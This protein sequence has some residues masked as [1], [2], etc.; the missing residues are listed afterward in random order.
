MFLAED[1]FEVLRIYSGVV[2]TSLFMVIIPSAC[3][4]IRFGTEFARAEPDNE[5][6]LGEVFR[7]PHLAAV[8]EFGCGKM[9]WSVMTSMGAVEPSR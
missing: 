7:P 8:Q 3:Q 4:C 2:A 6:E 9:L 1:Q 5:F